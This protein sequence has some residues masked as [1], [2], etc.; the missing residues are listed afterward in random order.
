MEFRIKYICKN[1]K[2][3]PDSFTNIIVAAETYIFSL[4]IRC[5][6]CF[7]CPNNYLMNIHI[8]YIYFYLFTNNKPPMGSSF[9]KPSLQRWH[10]GHIIFL[11]P[12]FRILMWSSICR[13]IDVV[14]IRSKIY[15]VIHLP[16]NLCCLLFVIKLRLS[17]LYLQI[18]VVFYFP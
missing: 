16:T 1:I 7:H 18:E 17:S 14:L 10:S 15:V 8:H 6:L 12:K 11:L 2:L 13:Q 3:M 4:S 5:L 9:P